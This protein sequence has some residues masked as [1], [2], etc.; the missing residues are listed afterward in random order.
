[1]RF[2]RPPTSRRSPSRTRRADTKT[3]RDKKVEIKAFVRA[4]APDSYAYIAPAKTP[5]LFPARLGFYR[6]P[7]NRA[8]L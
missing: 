5:M 1:V 3:V 6:S 2:L 8:L 7:I 4:C